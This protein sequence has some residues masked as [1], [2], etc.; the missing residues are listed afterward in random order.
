MKNQRL[1]PES[2]H[3]TFVSKKDNLG[4]ARS[5]SSRSRVTSDQQSDHL[6]DSR[7][8]TETCAIKETRSRS[9][10]D[11]D[12]TKLGFGYQKTDY[13]IRYT[14]RDGGWNEGVLT[15]DEVVPLHLAAACL[16]YGQECFEG[17]KAYET[18]D[19]DVVV[20][21]IEENAK[22]LARSCR[23]ILMEAVPEE[24]FV[25]AVSRVINANRRFVP[26]YGTGAS[27]YIR[28][29]VLGTGPQVGVKPAGEYSFIVFAT[30]VGP[31]F[32]AGFMPVDLVVEM[33]VDRA[34]PLGVGDVKVGG[35]YASGMRASMAAKDK[36]FAEVLFLDAREKRYIDESGPANFFA[37][38][39][40]QQYVTPQSESILPSITNDSLIVLAREMG[41]NPERRPIHVEEIFD[42]EEAGCCGTAAVVTP[43]GSIT[44]GDRKAVYCDDG[45]PGRH[46]T[47]LYEKLTAIQVGDAP[48]RHGW[49]RRVP[50][51]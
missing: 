11:I 23:K 20:F 28:P 18:A 2:N 17:L 41:L 16:H 39:N 10:A 7:R 45:T 14:W 49:L 43:V 32:K 15:P 44:Y 37:I 47:A 1:F 25:D 13:N 6:T 42:F 35:N 51:D 31:Y 34:A 19:G 22:R 24:M 46:C 33:D 27:M 48:D 21:R 30:P 12:W 38:T 3:M 8:T 26:P 29:L 40:G 36:G 4:F 5:P 9:K 50:V